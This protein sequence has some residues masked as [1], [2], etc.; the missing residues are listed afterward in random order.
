M[1]LAY[2]LVGEEDLPA[3]QQLWKEEA[4]WGTLAEELWRRYVVEAPLGGVSGAIA[5]D[6]ETGRVV[7]QF[8][9]V[10]SLIW[11]GGREVRAFRPGAPIVARSLRF[12]SPNPLS[13]PVVAMYKYAVKALRARG[14]GLIYMVPDARW[15]RLFR[16]FPFLRCGT[17]PLW[18]L[19][20]PLAAKLPLGDGYEAAP[21]DAGDA[22]VDRLWAAWRGLH[23]CQVVR[24]S[25]TLPWKLGDAT[26]EVVGVERGGELL[27]LAA[28]R[29]KGDRQWLVCDLLAADAG[30]SLRATLAAVANLAHDKA[31]EADATGGNPVRK[32]TVL[33]TNVIEPAARALGFVRDDYDFPLVVHVLDPSLKED[34]NPARWYVSAND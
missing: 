9:F 8:A 17:F 23:G 20:L 30:D 7:G 2:R 6:T 32:V 26:Y 31:L 34:I 3:V 12:R 24:D 1:G 25:R 27:G 16:V 14:D 5:T 28:S 21:L 10:P 4:N 13:H 11:V 22:R 15:V 33:T 18:R 19:P 29:R